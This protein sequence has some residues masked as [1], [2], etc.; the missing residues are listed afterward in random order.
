MVIGLII[1]GI[2]A[3][4]V[5][6]KIDRS[7]ID[8]SGYLDSSL[9]GWQLMYILPVAILT[10]DFFLSGFWM[11]TFAAKTDKDLG[12]GVSLATGAVAVILTL[13][14]VSGLLAGWS[15]ALGDP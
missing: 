9:L 1:M 15:G 5:E 11:R 4:G 7:L 14:G 3:V 2:I 12:V 6:T 10:N 8:K 13:I